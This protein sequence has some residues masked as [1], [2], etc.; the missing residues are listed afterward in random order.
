MVERFRCLI[1]KGFDV[2]RR[3]RARR[4]RHFTSAGKDRQRRNGLNA[5]ALAKVASAAK[6][7]AKD[8]K[9]YT[10]YLAKNC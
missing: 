8:V 6:T 4:A 10:S 9:K 3:T 5:E 1:D 2:G 7:Y